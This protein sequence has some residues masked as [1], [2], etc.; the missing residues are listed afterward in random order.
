MDVSLY[1][2][3]C[4]GHMYCSGILKYMLSFQTLV[5]N[6][7]DWIVH[8]VVLYQLETCCGVLIFIWRLSY[9]HHSTLVGE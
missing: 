4:I 2:I 5:T 6:N 8:V 9:I 3:M 1:R 7:V